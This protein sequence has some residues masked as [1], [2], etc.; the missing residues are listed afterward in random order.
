MWRIDRRERGGSRGPVVGPSSKRNPTEDRAG[1]SSIIK[2]LCRGRWR[3]V[4]SARYVK[5][6]RR[7]G[8]PITSDALNR[9][10]VWIRRPSGGVD[11]SNRRRGLDKSRRQ[12]SEFLRPGRKSHLLEGGGWKPLNGNPSGDERLAQAL[13]RWDVKSLSDGLKLPY[14]R[15]YMH[16][17][18]RNKS[19]F[20]AVRRNSL[21]LRVEKRTFGTLGG[22]SRLK[23][24]FLIGPGGVLKDFG[25]GGEG[26]RASLL[27]WH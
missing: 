18:G 4:F 23:D 21:K 19:I 15:G 27:K 8:R 2:S 1:P 12:P 5:G 25:K 22:S 16:Q 6:W 20:R 10:L 24:W 3:D 14:R 17:G 11:R 13:G 9:Q 7:S 26:E